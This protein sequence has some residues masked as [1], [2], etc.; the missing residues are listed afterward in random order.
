[1][2][3]GTQEGRLNTNGNRYCLLRG[4]TGA[5]AGTAAGARTAAGA[6]HSLRHA[7]NAGAESGECGHLTVGGLMTFGAFSV[8]AGLAKRAHLFK[9]CIAGRANVFVNRHISSPT[10]SVTC[11][12]SGV[13]IPVVN[14]KHT[15]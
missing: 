3:A 14:I 2:R 10:Y 5:A 1:M 13:K 12:N 9:F 11:L 4:A 8:L 6:G 15:V 7:A